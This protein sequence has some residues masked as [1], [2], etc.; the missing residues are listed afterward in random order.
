M[1]TLNWMGREKTTKAVKEVVM[2]ILR[3]DKS[4]SYGSGDNILVHGDNLEALKAL[5]PFYAGEVKCIY[6][7]PPYNTGSAFEHY[8]DNLEHSTWLNMMYPRLKLLREFLREDGSIWISIDDREGAYLRV[9]CDE[10][11]GRQNFVSNISWQRTYSTRNDAKG[12]VNEVEHILVYSKREGWQPKKLARTEEMDGKY[13][14]LDNDPQ[15]P[16]TSGDAFAADGAGHQGMVYAIQHPFTGEFIYP[17]ASAH[18][19]YGQDEMLS[20][21][22]GWCPYE[23]REI[24]DAE[25]RAAI[26]GV[27]VEEVRKGVK[28]IM[29]S[30]PLDES[31]KS[32]MVILKRG[33]WPKFYFTKNGKGGIRRKTYLSAVGDVPP[34][35]LFEYKD[36]GHTDEAKKEVLKVFDGQSPFATPKP[37]RLIKRVLEIATDEGDLVLDSFLGSGTTA[38]VAHKMRRRWIGIEM[39]DHAK[40]HCAVRL[41]KVVD[42]EQ[43]GIS[44]AVKWNGGGGFRYYELGEAILNEDGSLTG[45]I[46]FDVMAAHVWF[47]ETKTPW[48]ESK[49]ENVK[50]KIEGAKSTVLG[51][52]EGVAYVL[53][54]NGIL[55]DRSVNGGNV[56]T[57]KTLDVIQSDLAGRDYEKIVVYGEACRLMAPTLEALKIEFRQTPYDLVTRR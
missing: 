33:Q 25:K 28:A 46:P 5:L 7:D 36:V 27:G 1:P 55:R 18:W 47:S 54:Y 30:Q 16:W 56:L 41:K 34:T 14:N 42:G 9:I 26:C 17:Y 19:R 38:A 11:F 8:D 24:D 13:K 21:M 52:H 10:I 31:K 45:D 37:E 48:S 51:V 12:I 43:G 3:E 20:I 2:K 22:N 35:N 32:A 23:L 50:C 53:L 44:K 57:R 6:I 40:T 15:G 4:L 49:I 39:G 29:L